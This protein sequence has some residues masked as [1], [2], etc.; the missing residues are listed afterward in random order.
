MNRNLII[1][2]A[3]IIFIAACQSTHPPIQKF[4]VP[5][6]NEYI[7]PISVPFQPE[8]TSVSTRFKMS[9]TMDL[10]IIDKS[11]AKNKTENIEMVGSAKISK[12]A[13][14][15]T[16]E[17]NVKKLVTN[18]KTISPNKSLV[19]ARIFTDKF[20]KVHDLELSSPALLGSNVDQK[21]IDNFIKSMRQSMKSFGAV[22][23]EKPVITGDPITKIDKTILSKMI[24]EIGSNSPI[25]NDI[26]CIVKG[27]G[28]FNKKRVIV[29]SVDD[30]INIEI[31]K[32]ENLQIRLN[33]YSLF[34]PDSF[35]VVDS[36]LL[37]V[38]N[39]QSSKENSFSIKIL[40]QYSA[41]LSSVT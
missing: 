22:L 41:S 21:E 23:S 38:M 16:W 12:L 28:M 24:E 32:N 18:G 29:A 34:D 30:E 8:Y 10:S 4:G 39:T 3:I 11:L 37:I 13:D 2:S 20:G 25:D 5:K 7:T 6:Y 15:L 36:G 31:K 14:F 9:V 27:W 19:A 26:E 35:Q 40:M 33:G 17:V 1:F